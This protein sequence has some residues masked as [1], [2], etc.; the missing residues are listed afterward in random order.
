MFFMRR[1]E[2]G[3]KSFAAG[4]AFV[5]LQSRESYEA[6]AFHH[7]GGT[8]SERGGGTGRASGAD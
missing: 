7:H 3:I 4:T 2:I 6:L 8:A 1:S 5:N